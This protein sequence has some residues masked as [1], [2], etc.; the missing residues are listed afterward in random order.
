MAT[1][2]KAPRP[3]LPDRFFRQNLN[4]LKGGGAIASAVI[5]RAASDR[6]DY[7]ESRASG[8]TLSSTCMGH[9]WDASTRRMITVNFGYVT[10]RP[11]SSFKATPSSRVSATEQPFEGEGVALNEFSP[12]E[13][14][15]QRSEHGAEDGEKSPGTYVIPGQSPMGE[16][17]HQK[18]GGQSAMDE[19][20][21]SGAWSEEK[22]ES[23]LC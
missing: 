6:A 5:N 4:P 15:A 20:F 12:N 8:R 21:S 7:Q 1:L 13:H 16:T 9:F 22:C 19:T 11:V 3:V 18:T 23:E 14:R 17:K 10:L 2:A